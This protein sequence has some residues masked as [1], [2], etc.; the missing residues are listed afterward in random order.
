[1]DLWRK[2][3][4]YDPAFAF[5]PWACGFAFRRVLKHREQQARRAK[6]LSIESLN[7]IAAETSEQDGI[8]EDRRARPGEMPAAI[9]RRRSSRGRAPVFTADVGG[10]DRRDH[11]PEH[12]RA[13]QGARADPAPV[14][15]V[16]QSPLADGV[17]PL[18][19]RPSSDNER[20]RLLSGWCDGAVTDAE[21]DRLDELVRTD[22][23]FRDFYLK[24]MDQHAVLAAAVLPIG[25]V[26]LMVQCPTAACDEPS[27]RGDAVRAGSRSGFRDQR[28]GRFPRVPRL[29]TVDR[30][31]RGHSSWPA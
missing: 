25:D 10:Q 15:R 7:L 31:G 21:I 13:V 9:A 24:Y 19:A 18:M 30:R 8:L 5:A 26:R 3:D 17:L 22:P 2:F 16:R 20:H 4:R 6:Y 14:V 12:V 29:A 27:G 23:G 1:M 11:G 28:A